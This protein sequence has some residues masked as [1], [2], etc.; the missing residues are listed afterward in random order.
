[1]ACPHDSEPFVCSKCAGS[2]I[3]EVGWVVVLRTSSTVIVEGAP[4]FAA[5]LMAER[6]PK[7]SS[8]VMNVGECSC[9]K[10]Y[11]MHVSPGDSPIPTVSWK[12]RAT[13]K[14]GNGWRVCPP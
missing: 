8:A 9:A 12:G 2:G 7:V 13:F 11:C 1:M 5:R 3:F 6:L 10:P 4:R 14:R